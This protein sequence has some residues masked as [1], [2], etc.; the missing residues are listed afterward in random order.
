MACIVMTKCGGVCGGGKEE[1]TNN[2]IK[3]VLKP[4]MGQGIMLNTIRESQEISFLKLSGNP[5]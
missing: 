1:P 2:D 3:P 4:Q 5:D